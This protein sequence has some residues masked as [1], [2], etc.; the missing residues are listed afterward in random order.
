MGHRMLESALNGGF[1]RGRLQYF[2]ATA[3]DGK[4]GERTLCNRAKIITGF[5][6]HGHRQWTVL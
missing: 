3:A 5:L 4:M 1:P 6:Q 2:S